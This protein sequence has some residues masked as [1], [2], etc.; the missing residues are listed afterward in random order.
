ML[1][2]ELT[3][4]SYRL[5][6]CLDLLSEKQIVPLMISAQHRVSD[7][8]G[9]DIAGVESYATDIVHLAWREEHPSDVESAVIRSN[10]QM[11]ERFHEMFGPLIT[12][13]YS[14][15]LENMLQQIIDGYNNNQIHSNTWFSCSVVRLKVSV[16]SP[17]KWEDKLHNGAIKLETIFI[18]PRLQ[19]KGVLGH[20]LHYMASHTPETCNIKIE[21]CLPASASAMDNKYEGSNT[22]IFYRGRDRNNMVSYT[23]RNKSLF[24]EKVQ[25]PSYPDFSDL[26]RN[27][28]PSDHARPAWAIVAKISQK[29]KIGLGIHLVTMHFKAESP[30]TSSILKEKCLDLKRNVS[31]TTDLGEKDR[32]LINDALDELISQ[33]F[34]TKDVYTRDYDKLHAY[35]QS[36]NGIEENVFLSFFEHIGWDRADRPNSRCVKFASFRRY[37]RLLGIFRQLLVITNTKRIELQTFDFGEFNMKG[38]HHGFDNP[39][40]ICLLSLEQRE[41]IQKKMVDRTIL[42]G[43]SV[44]PHCD[45]EDNQCLVQIV[46][47]YTTGGGAKRKWGNDESDQKDTHTINIQFNPTLE[48]SIQQFQ[49]KIPLVI[50]ALEDLCQP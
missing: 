36:L 23:M 48:T 12:Q 10:E 35:Q 18:R 14:T 28:P 9:P 15:D 26:N 32:S 33:P 21:E 30:F 46:N 47:T 4:L 27:I 31:I 50:C 25:I 40:N 1:K 5:Q 19:R 29:Y 45:F 20:I 41:Y 16:D 34:L 22:D 39:K 24:I 44:L 2:N 7:F 37:T 13:T 49:E 43:W 3:M 38:L 42:M 8:L 17:F 11:E 6:R